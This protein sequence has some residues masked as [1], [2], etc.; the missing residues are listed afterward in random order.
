MR[1][2]YDVID[3]FPGAIVIVDT[4][5]PGQAIKSVTNDID[6]VLEDLRGIYG[7]LSGYKIM[8]RDTNGIFD[9]VSHENGHYRGFFSLNE[10]DVNAAYGKLMDRNPKTVAEE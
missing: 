5:R 7:S 10:K 1:S 6:N 2:S 8:Y 4:S 9:G 3:T